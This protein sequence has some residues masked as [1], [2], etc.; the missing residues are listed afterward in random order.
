MNDLFIKCSNVINKCDNR[1][2]MGAAFH[3][4]KLAGAR[5][6]D[7]NQTFRLLAKMWNVRLQYLRNK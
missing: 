2:Q 4:I 1:D 3:Y 6:N 5:F 7:N